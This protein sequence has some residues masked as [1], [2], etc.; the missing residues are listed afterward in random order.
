MTQ[1]ER[2]CLQ[3]WRCGFDPWV[4]GSP[5]GGHGTHSSTLA[6]RIPP[7]EE[8]GRLQ[9]IGLRRVWTQLRQVSRHQT[10]EDSSKICECG[11]VPYANSVPQEGYACKIS[12]AREKE[13]TCFVVNWLWWTEILIT[14][15][16]DGLSEFVIFLL[17][18]CSIQIGGRRAEESKV[19]FRNHFAQEPGNRK[20]H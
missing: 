14:G 20:A 7:T 10:K 9:S 15:F 16:W 1:W 8:P 3:C 11:W 17:Y 6:W 13:L 5:G 19:Y 4:G 18:F 2:T 12:E